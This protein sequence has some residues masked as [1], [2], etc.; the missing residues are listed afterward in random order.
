MVRMGFSWKTVLVSPTLG[1]YAA[2]AHD[3]DQP[4]S[5]CCQ[6][7]PGHA[8]CK[9]GRYEAIKAAA[10][11]VH[12]ETFGSSGYRADVLRLPGIV[13]TL[14]V[15]AATVGTGQRRSGTKRQHTV[16]LRPSGVATS[17]FS[18]EHHWHVWRSGHWCQ[19]RYHGHL[20][21]RWIVGDGWHFQ[22]SAIS[23]SI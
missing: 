13:A 6:L 21:C 17:V 4:P 3:F 1:P 11:D 2:I 8:Q 18:N 12:S 10:V 7:N 5:T 9:A 14:A 22:T 20:G 23:A 15:A 19:Q 16:P